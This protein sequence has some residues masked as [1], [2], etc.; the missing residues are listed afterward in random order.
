[1]TRRAVIPLRLYVC[2]ERFVLL[3]ISLLSPQQLSPTTR[4][5]LTRPS[6]RV[7]T[8][9]SP[10]Q[11]RL[12]SSRSS[13]A[14]AEKGDHPC[15]EGVGTEQYSSSVEAVPHANST[16]VQLER[17]WIW[18]RVAFATLRCI[19]GRPFRVS[20]ILCCIAYITSEVL[21]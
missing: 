21:A 13:L 9:C 19:L 11:D 14:C 15:I 7:N 20:G 5:F 1:M 18:P 3:V 2:R 4:S 16:H 10:R 6:V 8:I 17:R 12:S